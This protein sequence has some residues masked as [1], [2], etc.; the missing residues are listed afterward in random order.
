MGRGDSLVRSRNMISLDWARSIMLLAVLGLSAGPVLAEESERGPEDGGMRLGLVA[1]ALEGKE[2]FDVRVSLTNVS[3]HKIV[4]LGGWEFE[5]GGNVKD[6]LEGSVG[7]ESY[8]EFEPWRGGLSVTDAKR[9]SP[10]PTRTLEAGETLSLAWQTNGRRLKNS[11]IN[12]FVSQNPTFSIPG[13]YSVHA[14]LDV[15]TDNGTVRLRSN[16]Q[17]VPIGGSREMPRHTYGPLWSVN[18]K[19]LTAT[20][21]LGSNHKVQVGDV[22]DITNKLSAWQLTIT[23]VSPKYSEGTLKRLDDGS[24][25]SEIPKPSRFATLAE[26]AKK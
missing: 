24:D 14:S 11:V 1:K 19:K 21:G 9:T 26:K 17:L 15:I 22:F 3:K 16:E 5:E 23:Q 8:P 18:S 2:G 12:P 20:L 7:I 4:L 13:L 10:Q 25:E 6:F